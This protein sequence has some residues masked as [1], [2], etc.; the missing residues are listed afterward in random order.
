MSRRAVEVTEEVEKSACCIS[1]L[2]DGGDVY[3]GGI[4]VSRGTLC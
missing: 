3:D 2:E 4:A 1:E